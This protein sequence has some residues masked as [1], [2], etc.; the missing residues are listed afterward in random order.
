MDKQKTKI[1]FLLSCGIM[2]IYGFPNMKAAFY[3][4]MKAALCLSDVQLGRIWSVFG[5]VGMVSYVLGGY[6]T[7][8]ISPKKIII[9]ALT[10]SGILHFILSFIPNYWLLLVISGFMGIAAVFAFFPASSKILSSFGTNGS[11]GNIFGFYYALEGVGNTIFNFF[12]R[13]VYILSNNTYDT[14]VFM[15]R[16]YAVLD[17]VVAFLVMISFRD[18]HDFLDQGSRVSL[19]Q[20]SVVLKRKQVWLIA[21]IIMSCYVLY[22]SLTYITPYL[23]TVYG[24]GEAKNLTYA[25]IRV[26][27][28]AVLSGIIFGRISKQKKSV[29]FVIRKGMTLNIVCILAI[30]INGYFFK[31]AQVAIILTMVYAFMGIGM[32]SISMALIAEQ[33]FPI[34]ITGTI[35]GVASFIGYSPD[36]YLYA[37]IGKLLEQY[38][39]MGFSYMFMVYF[40]YMLIA[41][42]C[43][44]QLYKKISS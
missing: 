25:I 9:G 27:V 29:S 35:I 44:F 4:I 23:S 32:K 41:I 6:V 24:I 37:A 13:Q 2:G 16:F 15:V 22:C 11:A 12:G 28:L 7:D 5:I 10:L 17:I 30:M 33:N 40:L 39:Q 31:Q 3:N 1:I 42:I 26:D 8:R 43:C 34:A 38:Q 14:F 20:I 36:A 21:G 19:I 18:S